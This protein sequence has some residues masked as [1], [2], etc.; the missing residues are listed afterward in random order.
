MFSA[1]SSRVYL[2]NVSPSDRKL[3]HRRD[4][5]QLSPAKAPREMY[6]LTELGKTTVESS[7]SEDVTRN[8]FLTIASLCFTAVW[9]PLRWLSQVAVR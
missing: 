1:P 3:S 9:L 5:T 8:L 4:T 7:H 2:E 6:E